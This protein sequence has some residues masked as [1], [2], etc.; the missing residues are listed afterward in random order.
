MGPRTQLLLKIPDNPPEILDSEEVSKQV[1]SSTSLCHL[2]DA[3]ATLQIISKPLT[4]M[5]FVWNGAG[6]T[7]RS[8]N[9]SQLDPAL[10]YI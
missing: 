9:G 6:V 3:L 7:K 8:Q 2:V 10:R 4:E 1:R 5:T